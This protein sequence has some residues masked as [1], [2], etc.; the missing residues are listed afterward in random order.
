VSLYTFSPDSLN[1]GRSAAWNVRAEV[2][3]LADAGAS[4]LAG[5]ILAHGWSPLPGDR[6]LYTKGADGATLAPLIAEVI[7][8]LDGRRNDAGNVK[9]VCNGSTLAGIRARLEKLA[10]R[11]CAGIVVDGRRRV[12]AWLIAYGCGL[13]MEPEGEEVPAGSVCTAFA[14][15]YNRE[16]ASRLDPWA[17]V[18]AGERTMADM[19]SMSESELMEALAVKRG[20][21]QLIHRAA[22]AIRKHALVPDRAARCPGKEDWKSILECAT[23][24]EAAAKLAEYQTGTRDKAIGLPQLIKALEVMPETAAANCR[25]LG[26]ACADRATLDAFLKALSGK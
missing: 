16:L 12:L 15:N 19:P 23:G 26:K 6:V 17:K 8:A 4:G 21:G 5:M 13:D 7:A 24:A 1:P 22:S 3:R 10:D 11:K 25:E 9:T 14:A 20:D 2:C 18:E